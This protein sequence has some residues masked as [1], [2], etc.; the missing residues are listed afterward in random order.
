[1]RAADARAGGV[2]SSSLLAV[3]S[4]GTGAG[5]R[6]VVAQVKGGVSLWRVPAGSDLFN[7]LPGLPFLSRPGL[8]IYAIC[9][10]SSGAART[11]GIRF[12]AAFA[13]FA[14][15]RAIRLFSQR[16]R[17]RGAG[18]LLRCAADFSASVLRVLSFRSADYVFDGL[19]ALP[20]RH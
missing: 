3:H 9:G 14:G 5:N 16:A 4:R 17:C 11:L 7:F 12:P 2:A 20:L 15:R 6:V 8:A 19:S 10:V 13:G 18:G 1:E